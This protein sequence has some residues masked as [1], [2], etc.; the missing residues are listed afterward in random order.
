MLLNAL[1]TAL[2]VPWPALS[3]EAQNAE[4]WIFRVW[5]LLRDTH[6][7]KSCHGVTVIT[8]ACKNT[9]LTFS[10]QASSSACSI[11]RGAR[12]WKPGRRATVPK[13]VSPGFHTPPSCRS[14]LRTAYFPF[15]PATTRSKSLASPAKGAA[16]PLSPCLRLRPRLSAQP[17]LSQVTDIPGQCLQ[18]NPQNLQGFN[19]LVLPNSSSSCKI[20]YLEES[21]CIFA[22]QLPV[23]TATRTYM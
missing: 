11:S 17:K 21:P 7:K 4:V 2:R 19:P 22:P 3:P 8:S 10:M 16:P 6:D 5:L 14:L 1:N 12:G 9:G 15:V 23:T 20:P 13:H 18:N